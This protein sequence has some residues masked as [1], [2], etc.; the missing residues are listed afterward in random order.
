VQPRSSRELFQID[1]VGVVEAGNDGPPMNTTCANKASSTSAVLA[2][3]L[4]R[5]LSSKTLFRSAL[6]SGQ[7]S[8]GAGPV[9]RQSHR[10]VS[11]VTDFLP[12]RG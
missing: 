3:P 12:M 11:L 9:W 8:A 7:R 5:W 6:E 1:C 2:P 4:K 10:V